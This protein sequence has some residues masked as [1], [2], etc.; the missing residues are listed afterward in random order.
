MRRTIMHSLRVVAL[1]LATV[2]IAAAADP[3]APA[4]IATLAP[5]SVNGPLPCNIQGETTLDQIITA[6]RGFR[7]IS[8][9][10]RPS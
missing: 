3:V 1:M 9:T 8:R 10:G 6:G 5:S 2:T 7:S 4:D